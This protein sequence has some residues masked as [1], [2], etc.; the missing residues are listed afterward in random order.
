MSTLIIGANGSMGRRYQA[1]LRYLKKPFLCC[2]VGDSIDGKFNIADSFIV[3]TPTDTHWTILDQLAHYG[4]PVLCEKPVVKSLED[5][6]S[7][8]Y[9]YDKI[10]PL[11]MVMQYRHLD[12]G[13]MGESFYNYYNHGKDGLYWDTMQIIGLARGEV[14]VAEDSPIWTCD[15]NG[16]S[17]SI[18]YMDYAYISM[19]QDWFLNPK[20]DLNK[21][22]AIHEKV[23]EMSKN[24]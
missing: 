18:G 13:R 19:I 22:Y 20:D 1:I 14:K 7:I 4:K 17:L 3:A 10:T 23:V 21:V 6:K 11:K 8:I 15:L 5:L 9:L 12:P 16:K 2:D 24:G